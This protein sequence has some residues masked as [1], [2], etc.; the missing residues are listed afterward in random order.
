MSFASR[1]AGTSERTA[2]TIPFDEW[3]N[4]FTY[5]GLSYAFGLNQTLTGNVEEIGNH[6]DGLVQGAYRSNGIVFACIKARQMLISQAR[7]QFQELRGGRPGDL[8]GTQAL[9]ILERPEP[10]KVTG[11]LLSAASVD[12]DIAGNHFLARR[13]TNG[14]LRLK[15]LR[16]HWVDIV[17]GSE[18]GGDASDIDAEVLGYVYWPGGRDSGNDGIP[19][20]REQVAHFAP[21]RDPSASYRGMSWLSPIIRE[22]QGDSA[23]TSHKLKFF[24]N[25]ATVNLI[26]QTGIPD[27]DKFKEWVKLFREGHEGAA[28]A[29]KTLF[30]T[31]GADATAVGADFQQMDFKSVQGSGETRIA[32]ASGMHPV[33]IGA[34][35]GLAGSSLNQGNFMAARR[36]VADKEL[37]PWWSN[38]AGSLETI[39]PPPN[40]SRLW[41]DDRHIPFLAEDVKDAVEAQGVQSR[42]I[43]TLVDAGYTSESVVLAVNNADWSRLVHSGLYSV[44]LQK[45]GEKSGTNVNGPA[46]AEPVATEA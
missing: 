3:A 35:E 43:R 29:H 40:G 4:Y 30:L 18:D 7:F 44:Q 41:Y 19:L 36:L 6:F 20:L 28:N 5:N 22:I 25:G 38:F 8:F 32:M 33:I 13:I 1:V 14:Q 45:P 16:P 26:V 31:P 11:D 10:G 24:E 12:A 9:G 15:R 34:S 42:T 2:P 27:P 39:I 37:R 23:A 17:L 46:V 21:V